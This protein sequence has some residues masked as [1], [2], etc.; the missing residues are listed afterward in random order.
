GLE[1]VI[2]QYKLEEWEPELAARALGDLYACLQ[3]AKPKPTPEDVKRSTEVF[4][5]LCRLDPAAALKLEAASGAKA[6]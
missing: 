5:R 6:K 2:K 4:A 1:H 3:R